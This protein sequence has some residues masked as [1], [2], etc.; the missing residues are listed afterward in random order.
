[1]DFRQVKEEYSVIAKE[2]IETEPEL[3]YIKKSQV[4]IGY[5]SSKHQKQT[6][7]KIIF[8]EC[9]KVQDKNKWAMPYD[10]TITVFEPNVVN[11]TE[12]QK[13]ILIF[14]EL[15]HVGIEKKK[16]VESYFI[17]PHDLE[18]FKLII[19]KYGTEW[20]KEGKNENVSGSVS[21]R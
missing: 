3:A 1:M 2:L 15:L 16:R 5:L 21:S 20:N 13:R 8:A 17:V 18:D 9:E 10:F 12:E 19:D 14:H 4:R 11:F 7:L 6:K